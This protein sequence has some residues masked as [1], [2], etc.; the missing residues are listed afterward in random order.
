LLLQTT[1]QVPAP[2]ENAG[3]DKDLGAFWAS[4]RRDIGEVASCREFERAMEMN[5]STYIHYDLL[6][7]SAASVMAVVLAGKYPATAFAEPTEPRPDGSI[8]VRVTAADK[9]YALV[10]PLRWRR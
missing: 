8:T 10:D 5:I 9:H 3:S 2:T 6:K 1:G 4:T 7:M